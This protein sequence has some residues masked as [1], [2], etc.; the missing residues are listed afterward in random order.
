M[1]VA[2]PSDLQAVC[3][4]LKVRSAEIGVLRFDEAKAQETIRPIIESRLCFVCEA[5]GTIAASLGL[6]FAE[7]SWDSSDSGMVDRWF[8]VHPEHRHT[9]FAQELVLMAKKAARIS[10]VPLWLSVSATKR[11][12]KKML[13]ME[14]YMRTFG[15]TF[16]YIPEAA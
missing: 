6:T 16:Y 8:F 15:G 4:L 14:R 5:D 9:Q 10:Q 3:D 7:P 11:S 1:R 12:V 2:E 13:F